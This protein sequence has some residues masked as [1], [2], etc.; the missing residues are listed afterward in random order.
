MAKAKKKRKSAK[1]QDGWL[2]SLLR[3][4]IIVMLFSLIG[5]YYFLSFSPIRMPKEP[6]AS[7][8]LTL[9]L[10]A[11]APEP[12]VPVME[13]GAL[14]VEAAPVSEAQSELS[15]Q[16]DRAESNTEPLPGTVSDLMVKDPNLTSKQTISSA[17][18]V[19]VRQVLEV[20]SYVLADDIKRARSQLEDLGFKVRSTVRKSPT[21][22]YRVFL[23]PFSNRQKTQKMMAVARKMGDQPFIHKLKTGN[24]VVV[25][26]FYLKESVVAWEN[27]YHDAGLEPKVRQESLLIPHTCLLLD[28][29][30]VDNNPQVVLARVKAAGFSDARLKKISSTNAK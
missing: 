7:P 3:F 28:G 11:P 30:Q 27:M 22:M 15:D 20:G 9:A 24:I 12:V 14:Q 10:L 6:I 21:L 19:V 23:G 13:D 4:E 1:G 18:P 26:S 8:R 29:S 16:D 17:T 5:F 2:E 25:G